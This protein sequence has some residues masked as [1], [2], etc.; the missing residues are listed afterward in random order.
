MFRVVKRKPIMSVIYIPES[1]KTVD[2][3]L[4][5]FDDNLI[6]TKTKKMTRKVIISTCQFV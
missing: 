4:F 5:L 1:T 3:Q 2:V 6:I